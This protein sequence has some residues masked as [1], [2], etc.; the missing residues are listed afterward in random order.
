MPC[1][2]Q[3]GENAQVLQKRQRIAVVG[4]RAADRRA[5]DPCQAR[6]AGAAGAIRCA[7]E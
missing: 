7:R 1:A 3:A 5:G 6:A 2:R 4:E